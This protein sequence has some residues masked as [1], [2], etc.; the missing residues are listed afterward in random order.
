MNV[1]KS[2]KEINLHDHTCLVFNNQSE[3]FRHLTPFVSDSFAKNEK[4]LIVIDDITRKEV[5]QNLKPVFIE[6]FKNVYLKDDPFGLEQ[7][8]DSVKPQRS[9]GAIVIENFKNVY[10][11]RGI[12]DREETAKYYLGQV[13]HALEQGYSGLRLFAEVS[14][15]LKNL[16]NPDDFLRYEEWVDKFFPES[17]FSAVCSYN[18]SLFSNE[19][20]QEAIR[21]HPVEIR[22]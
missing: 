5:I 4:C 7:I 6:N 20:I 12:F 2:I 16:S 8:T 22:C 11:K 10:L 9:L 19:Y 21:I 15:T 14:S 18:K 13:N 1:K 3:F 17:K